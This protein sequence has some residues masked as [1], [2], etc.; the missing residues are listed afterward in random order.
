MN[1][2]NSLISCTT[3]DNFKTNLSPFTITFSSFSRGFYRK[4]LTISAFVKRKRN[5]LSPK[6][7]NMVV[8]YLLIEGKKERFHW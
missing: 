4:R 5:N 7:L 8:I 2:W 1:E 6:K 3:A